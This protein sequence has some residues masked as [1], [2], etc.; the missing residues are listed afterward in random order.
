MLSES[1][2]LG[3]KGKMKG[4]V[5]RP[6]GVPGTGLGQGVVNPEAIRGI[7]GAEFDS[8]MATMGSLA[9]MYDGPRPDCAIAGTCNKDG[10]QPMRKQGAIILATG[11]DNS[12]GAMGKFYE[13]F[14]VTGD[15]TDTTD[16]AV[17]SNIVAVGYRQ[18]L[19]VT[20]TRWRR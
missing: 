14:M 18:L 5:V 6:T 10:Y 17:Q 7:L 13:G 1:W 19:P 20:E 12:N 9:T 4:T 8:Y 15:T 16:D 2:R 11:G 3:S